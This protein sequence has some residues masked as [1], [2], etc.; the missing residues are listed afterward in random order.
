MFAAA[1]TTVPVAMN[2]DGYSTRKEEEGI[3][4]YTMD[5]KLGVIISFWEDGENKHATA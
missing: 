3:V 1:F 5:F 4:M 2:K